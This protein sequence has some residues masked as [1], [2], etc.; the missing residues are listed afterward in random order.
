MNCGASVLPL[1]LLPTHL[2]PTPGQNVS[3]PASVCPAVSP[4]GLR[5]GGTAKVLLPREDRH[6]P[7]PAA[8]KQHCSLRG[9]SFSWVSAVLAALELGWDVLNQ[10]TRSPECS[11]N[12]LGVQRRG[13]AQWHRAPCDAPC[14]PGGCKCPTALQP[15]G[16]GLRGTLRASEGKNWAFWGS[17]LR[18]VGGLSPVCALLPV[19]GASLQSR[20][21]EERRLTV[22]LAL[23][24]DGLWTDPKMC[25]APA[26]AEHMSGLGA[27]AL[28]QCYEMLQVLQAWPGPP[29]PAWI[30]SALRPGH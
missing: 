26:L 2:Q 13:Q 4:A 3:L 17:E 7:C 21:P 22:I 6:V 15:V 20:V 9:V 19:P 28:M 14:P 18:A 11:V 23:P 27:A 25:L 29:K 24:T 30:C 1:P 10:G 16:T 12:D 5:A 8:E